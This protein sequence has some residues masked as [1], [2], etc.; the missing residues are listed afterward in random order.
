[1]KL[2]HLDPCPVVVDEFA[3]CSIRFAE[4]QV[5]MVGRKPADIERVTGTLIRFAEDG[6]P[7]MERYR[8]ESGAAMDLLSDVP[9]KPEESADKVIDMRSTFQGM[10]CRWKPRGEEAMDLERAALGLSKVK[11]LNYSDATFALEEESPIP[12]L[13]GDPET[14]P[15]VDLDN[16]PFEGFTEPGGHLASKPGRDP[17]TER[18][19]AMNTPFP[20]IRLP[21]ETRFRKLQRLQ[22]RTVP[23]DVPLGLAVD[24]VVL[25][26]KTTG[27]TCRLQGRAGVLTLRTS[28]VPDLVPGRILTVKPDRV[29]AYQGHTYMSGE[30]VANRMDAAALGLVPLAMEDWGPWDP[31]DE[32]WGDPGEPLPRWARPIVARGPR[33]SFELEAC[34]PGNDPEDWDSDA[35]QEAIEFWNSGKKVQA[36]RLLEAVCQADLRC[37]DA[38]AHLGAFHFDRHPAKALLHYHMGAAIGQLSLGPDFEGVLPWGCLG[39]R[40]FLRCLH[41]FGLCLWRL[42][43]FTE[44]KGVFERMLWM[45]PS[46]NQGVRFVLPEV[47]AKR[48]W[49]D[50]A[51]EEDG[52]H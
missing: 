32:Y 40:P 41:G 13:P 47:R 35:I 27:A 11:G 44:A 9:G 3:G 14:T 18:L 29:W 51:A 31:K 21:F 25:A 1:M 28:L 46:D 15:A 52:S 22:P 19:E 49:E 6:R 34:R 23:A 42:G 20:P 24:L 26:T 45:N 39:N 7:D 48:S 36:L 8:R 33:P 43:F 16:L 5:R 37:L 30:R 12:R 10:G 2:L 50:F 17:V 4:F 38:H